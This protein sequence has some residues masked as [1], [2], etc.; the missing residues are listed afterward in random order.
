MS[1]GIHQT[2]LR[3]QTEQL[4]NGPLKH[5]RAAALAAALLPLASVAASPAVAQDCTSA[6]T[7]CGTVFLDTNNSNTQDAGDTSIHEAIV[8]IST[9]DGDFS[10]PTDENGFWVFDLLPGTYEVTVQ[11]P[12][13]M[14]A[15]TPH[16]GD[17]TADSDGVQ[18]DVG[19]SVASVTLDE[20]EGFDSSTDFGFEPAAEQ[21]GTGTPGYWK[22]HP[23]AWPVET[24][25]IG[26]VTYTKA[27]AISWLEN[28][29]KDK[30]TTMFSSLLSAKLNV[31]VGN[32]ASCVGSTITAA[33]IWMA[34]HGPVGSNVHASSYAWKVG[35]PL[36]RHMDNYNNGMLCAAHRN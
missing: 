18:N 12:N 22:N 28:V 25:V 8:T 19:Q 7:V 24:I 17:D 20:D 35:E 9:P 27:L 10:I 23:E 11:I 29:G 26:G 36:H 15:V 21:P 34:T 3:E 32:D 13:L 16:V 1:Q 33:D 4:L 5:V 14:Q 2:E 6:G 30:T 31:M